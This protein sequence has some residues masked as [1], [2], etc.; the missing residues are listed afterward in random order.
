MSDKMDFREIDENEERKTDIV[1]NVEESIADDEGYERYCFLCHRPESVTGKLIDLPNDMSVCSDCMNKSFEAMNHPQFDLSKLM[2]T[3]GIQ[4]LNMSDLDSIFPK[5]QRVK[6]KK[7]SEKKEP[8]INIKDIPAP[9]KI[10]AQLDDYVIGQEHAKKAM[11][12]AVY[13]H[14][15]RV[16]T[17]TWMILKLR[18]P[19]CL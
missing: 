11:A 9:H 5:Q 4:F 12:V 18:N 15:K 8:A 13:N 16:A 10:K 14:Y 17:D 3:P 7:P 6:K 19:T 1:E 2:N